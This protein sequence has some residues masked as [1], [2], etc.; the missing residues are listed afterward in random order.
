MENIK[1]HQDK[2]VYAEV[3]LP[4]IG[5]VPIIYLDQDS[6]DDFF[7]DAINNIVKNGASIIKEVTYAAHNYMSEMAPDAVNKEFEVMS[8][9]VYE[10]KPNE[11]GVSLHWEGDTEHGIG[12]RIVGEEVVEIGMEDILFS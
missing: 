5:E 10:G 8:I 1:V 3:N 11:I 7:L 2:E 4:K 6:S 9:F 12:I